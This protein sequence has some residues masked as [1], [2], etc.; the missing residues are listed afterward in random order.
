MAYD[1]VYPTQGQSV[2]AFDSNQEDGVASGFGDVGEAINRLNVMVRTVTGPSQTGWQN[3]VKINIPTNT[4]GEYPVIVGA[5][6]ESGN[7]VWI[8]INPTE[9]Q[10]IIYPSLGQIEIQLLSASRAGLRVRVAVM[11]SSMFSGK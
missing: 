8:I 10:I 2:L 1:K 4:L 6:Y 3:S 7:G 11:A 9:Y 5:M